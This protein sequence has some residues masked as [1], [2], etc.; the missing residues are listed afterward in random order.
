MAAHLLAVELFC[1]ISGICRCLLLDQ[2]AYGSQVEDNSSEYSG[3]RPAH[4]SVTEAVE[5]NQRRY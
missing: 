1:L 4:N 3:C 2:M 5:S